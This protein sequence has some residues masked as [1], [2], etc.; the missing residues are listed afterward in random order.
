MG[1]RKSGFPYKDEDAWGNMGK[2]RKDVRA[3]RILLL[4]TATVAQE[5]KSY[6][7]SMLAAKKLPG[8]TLSSDKR[9][10][11]DVRLVNALRDKRDCP[12]VEKPRL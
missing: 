9:L 2:L 11:S 3:G 1:N 12:D 5:E 6:A 7:P 4:S 10:I 8:T